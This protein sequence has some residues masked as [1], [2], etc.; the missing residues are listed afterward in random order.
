[1]CKRFYSQTFFVLSFQDP[2]KV[3]NDAEE[4]DPFK[5]NECIIH[6]FKV[7]KGKGALRNLLDPSPKWINGT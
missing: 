3:L 4:D 1:L 6:A 7:E 5:F 2:Y